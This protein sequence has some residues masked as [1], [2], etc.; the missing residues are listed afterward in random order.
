MENVLRG[1]VVA[2]SLIVILTNI[3]ITIII[4]IV[5]IIS[6]DGLKIRSGKAVTTATTATNNSDE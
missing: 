4:I 2:T 1:T 6:I 5:S 3:N